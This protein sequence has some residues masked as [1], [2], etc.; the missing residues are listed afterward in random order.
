MR[1]VDEMITDLSNVIDE[2]CFDYDFTELSQKEQIEFL[3]KA[4]GLIESY[5][6]G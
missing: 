1:K 3:E 5:F 4:K 6:I 2:G